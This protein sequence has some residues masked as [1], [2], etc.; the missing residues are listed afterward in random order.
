MANPKPNLVTDTSALSIDDTTDKPQDLKV[1]LLFSI[2][3]VDCLISLD[4]FNIS[5]LLALN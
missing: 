4:S 2:S 1:S 5:C 3:L